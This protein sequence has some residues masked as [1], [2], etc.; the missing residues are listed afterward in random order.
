[1]SAAPG[2]FLRPTHPQRRRRRPAFLRLLG[3]LMR[4]LP[5]LSLPTAAWFWFTDGTTF[6]LQAVE[7]EGSPRISR[8]WVE[9]TVAPEMGSNL[10]LLPLD[11]VRRRLEQ[12]PW[13]GRVEARKELPSVL[14][15]VVEEKVA[16][17][18]LETD[19]GFY[20]VDAAGKRIARFEPGDSAGTL[21]R[22]AAGA[23]AV[24]ISPALATSEAAS[25]RGALVVERE[26]EEQD[27]PD[28]RL[29]LLW[30]EVVGDDDF[31][32]YLD[33]VPFS[34]LVRSESV[35][36][37]VRL[38]ERLRPEILDRVEG[39]AEV[40][41]RFESRVIVRPG[42]PPP[43]REPAKAV[44]VSTGD[45]QPADTDPVEPATASK[46]STVWDPQP[47]ET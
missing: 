40:D 37:R 20:F 21:P 4:V 45:A 33:Q 10:L 44:V 22:I 25:V 46:R 2:P 15:V 32:I 42:P 1:M 47:K 7:T 16:A 9:Q 11:R 29:P 34:I 5:V 27:G 43:E 23:T 28:W 8:D 3:R 38:L 19:D 24:G 39:I 35:A 30:V 12:H 41:L 18:V 31:R 14:R 26:L 6:A 17:A 36:Q 13:L